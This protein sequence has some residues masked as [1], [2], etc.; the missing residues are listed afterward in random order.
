MVN[1]KRETAKKC[2]IKD[3]ING[4]YVKREGWEPNYLETDLGRVSRVN[5]LG[6]IIGEDEGVFTIDDG[7]GKIQVRSFDEEKKYS[8][9]K[10][11]DI[12]IVIGRPR[13]FNEQK[14]IVLE[15]IKTIDNLKWIEYRMLELKNVKTVPQQE[16]KIVP[17]EEQTN[18]VDIVDSLLQ[19]ISK[20]DQGY[21]VKIDDLIKQFEP[22]TANRTISRLIEQGEIFEI[23]PGLVKTI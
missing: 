15:I 18:Q 17:A 9:K 5:I 11:G 12:V 14:Y 13:V 7:T 20:L 8:E 23:K 10:I 16:E 21:G 19:A 3:L 2:R 6:I 4:R 22:V 1:I